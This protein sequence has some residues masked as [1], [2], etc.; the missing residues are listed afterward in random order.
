MKARIIKKEN[1]LLLIEWS[2]PNI[3]FGQLT[4]VW[5]DVNNVYKLDSELMGMDTTLLILKAALQEIEI[6]KQEQFQDVE[7]D[8]VVF[9]GKCGK[10]K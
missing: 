7:A 4:M 2:D 3:G 1:N 9:C 8:G 5:D 6:F 10:I